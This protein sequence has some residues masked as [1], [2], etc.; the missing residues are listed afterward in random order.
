MV[1]EM[2]QCSTILQMDHCKITIKTHNS[3]PFWFKLCSNVWKSL[4]LKWFIPMVYRIHFKKI[5]VK[6]CFKKN[7]KQLT[8]IKW[9]K[10]QIQ[11][12]NDV[13]IKTSVFLF[14]KLQI[15]TCVFYISGKIVFIAKLTVFSHLYHV[16]SLLGVF[17]KT[18]TCIHPSK[19][20][21]STFIVYIYC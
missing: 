15:Y 13:Y 2:D 6:K 7:T 21:V 20:T 17:I 5:S 3:V 8:L 18:L 12:I 14:C 16:L 1:L 19:K 10:D 4:G 9:L 11:S